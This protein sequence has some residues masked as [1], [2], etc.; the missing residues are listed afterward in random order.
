MA[1]ATQSLSI[2]ADRTA[3]GF[4]KGHSV[5]VKAAS[6]LFGFAFIWAGAGIWLVP[7]MGLEP[8]VLL[9]KMFLSVMMVTAGVGMTQIATEKPRSELHF[10]AS[11][12]QVHLVESLPRGRSH[13]VKSL[14]YEDI[15]RVSVTDSELVML[16]DQSKILVEL[17]L[18][19]AHARLDAIAQLRSQSLYAA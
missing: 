13:V 17:P 18:D 15:A 8:S 16:N 3:H 7:G 10:D 2:S 6:V 14:N 1:V 4:A 9:T 11:H 19:G 5:P 12:R